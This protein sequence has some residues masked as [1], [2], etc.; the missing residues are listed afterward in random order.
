MPNGTSAIMDEAYI[1][2]TQEGTYT[3][4][5]I[6]WNGFDIVPHTLPTTSLTS[7][8]EWTIN[9]EVATSLTISC[10]PSTSKQD[11]QVVIEGVLANTPYGYLEGA[12]VTLNYQV[13]G[14]STWTL[15]TSTE[16]GGDGSFTATWSPPAM[17][18]Y[19]IK[20]TWDGNSSYPG[21]SATLNLATISYIDKYVFSVT[22]NSSISD[23]AFNS[24]S[25]ELHFTLTGPTGTTGFAEVT[26]AK[27][28]VPEMG[29][30][31]VYL[32]DA[33]VSYTTSSAD[34]SWRLYFNYPHSTHAVRISI[35]ELPQTTI[36]CNLEQT[37]ITIGSDITVWG[38]IDP[39]RPGAT[40]IL[41]Y[42]F[43]NATV[44]ERTVTS[45]S[46]GNYSDTYTPPV[47]GSWSVKARWE[48]DITYAGAMSSS[49]SF[50]V[51]KVSTTVSCSVTPSEVTQGASVT[52]S[53]SINPALSGKT[54][55]LTYTKPDGT[56]LTRTVTTGSDGSYSDS[57]NVDAV[58]SWSVKASWD[59]DSTHA[60]ASSSSASFTVSSPAFPWWW[61]A[62]AL[63]VVFGA[64]AYF[65]TIRRR[66]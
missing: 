28:L 12:T 10:K 64:I 47:V 9:C 1:P 24:I 45:T 42:T 33:E 18:Y 52:V 21:G 57:Y 43:P 23:L 53:G 54:V 29:N 65:M 2:Q 25:R 19:V 17:G 56:S 49:V 50:N 13:S 38:S 8:Y 59:G 39:I 27:D 63:V 11:F 3:I 62:L 34:G 20:A 26:I 32:D 16:T 60:S 51:T 41:T 48:G 7:N 66:R 61:L 15:I 22:T 5:H 55:T 35:G 4:E 46:D 40:V 58:G 44:I 36:S 6:I 37:E 30:L 31:K 14:T